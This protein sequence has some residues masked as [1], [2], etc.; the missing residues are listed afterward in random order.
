M[1]EQVVDRPSLGA[2]LERRSKQERLTVSLPTDLISYVK[3]V[4]ERYNEAQSAVVAE[5]LRRMAVEERRRQLIDGLIED[6]E[7]HQ[8]LAREEMAVVAPLPE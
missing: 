4:A 2:F 8:E 7:W 1:L 3:D 6:A 5:A